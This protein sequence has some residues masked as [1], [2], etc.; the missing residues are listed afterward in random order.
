MEDVLV[1]K[2]DDS[3]LREQKDGSRVSSLSELDPS[4]AST[5]SPTGGKPL[6]SSDIS[7]RAMDF[8]GKMRTAAGV[9]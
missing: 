9:I 2:S 4:A 5:S 6:R 3:N 1:D 8:N 7:L